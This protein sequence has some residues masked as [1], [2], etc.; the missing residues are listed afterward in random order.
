ML[1]LVDLIYRCT[2]KFGT[3]ISQT[4]AFVDSDSDALNWATREI[5]GLRN[6]WQDT[7]YSDICL[8][9]PDPSPDFKIGDRLICRIL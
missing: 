9:E 8:Y 2:D 5:S 4:S 6:K 7:E 3:W 1:M